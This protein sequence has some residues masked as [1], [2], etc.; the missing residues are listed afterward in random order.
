MN[1]EELEKRL[2]VCYSRS[3]LFFGLGWAAI[4]IGVIVLCLGL[5]LMGFAD[6]SFVGSIT[7]LAIA[8]GI[9][10]FILDGVL[11]KR[12]IRAIN[13]ELEAK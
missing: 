12:K 13:H 9:A 8:G 4:G 3:A 7:P 10:L 1:K 6:I 5:F 11:W 2:H